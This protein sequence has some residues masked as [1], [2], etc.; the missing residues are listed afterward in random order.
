MNYYLLFRLLFGES[1]DRIVGWIGAA[2]GAGLCFAFIIGAVGRLW[3]GEQ[4]DNSDSFLPK[5]PWWP[6]WRP[7][8]AV[9]AVVALVVAALVAVRVLTR[10]Q[11]SVAG[12]ALFALVV[13]ALAAYSVLQKPS[14]PTL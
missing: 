9:T 8:A 10:D 7:V 4:P 11:T 2:I 6:G 1:V 13:A 14:P 5:G 12:W 3:S